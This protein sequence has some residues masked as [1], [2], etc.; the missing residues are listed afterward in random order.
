MS[1][2]AIRFFTAAAALSAAATLAACSSS[3][4]S[5]SSSTPPSTQPTSSA[6][7]TTAAASGAVSGSGCASLGVTDEMVAAAAKA[8]VGT[9][10][11]NAPFLSSVTAAANVAGLIPTLNAAPALTIFAPV[12]DAFKKEDPARVQSLLTDPAKK[13]ELVNQLELHVLGEEVPKDQLVGTHKTL[14]ATDM[15]ITGSGDDFTVDGTAK[16]ICGG[17]KASNA[18]IYLIDTVLQPAG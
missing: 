9:V 3:G 10:A 6:P 15:V 17:I 1:S 16:I 12:D 4:G 8:P 2:H 11:A 18:I 14:A 13:P 5:S 7:S